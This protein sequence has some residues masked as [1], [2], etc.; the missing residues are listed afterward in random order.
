MSN[1]NN[2][3]FTKKARA[4]NYEARSVYKLQE[5]ERR[6]HI[7]RNVQLVLDLGASPGSWTHFCLEAAPHARVIA[8]DIAPL[9]FQAPRVT[10]IQ[11]AVENLDLA[12]ILG[13][14]SF[15]VVL[16][17]MA[18]KTSGIHD[19]DVALSLELGHQALKIANQHL[20][21]GGCLL[22]KIFMG[23]SFESFRKDM[24]ACFHELR[25]LR[26]ESTRKHS[27]EIYLIGKQF[28]GPKHPG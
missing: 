19:R 26:P 9:T 5:I 20:R 4:E 16:S 17:D 6:E 24:K 10:F 23:S 8:V 13:G 18:P 3:P 22:T 11:V 21:K 7:F 28:I 12:P 15:D 1:W 14:K 25:L 2:D 27:R